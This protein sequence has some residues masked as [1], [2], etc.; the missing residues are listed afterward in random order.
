MHDDLFHFNMIECLE[1]REQ[2]SR[3][4]TSRKSALNG[5]I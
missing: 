5:R 2:V 1:Y 3:L 4:I